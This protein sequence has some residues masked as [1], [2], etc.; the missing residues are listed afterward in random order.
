MLWKIRRR[1]I[2][3]PIKLHQ[4]IADSCEAIAHVP[5][6]VICVRQSL[7]KPSSFKKSVSRK[8]M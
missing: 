5:S 2:I 4:K 1:S 6:E 7:Q 8:S 3:I